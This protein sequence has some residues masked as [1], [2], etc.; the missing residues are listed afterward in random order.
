MKKTYKSLLS[1]TD[2]TDVT[3]ACQNNKWVK[4]HK[5]ILSSSSIFFRDLLL[6]NPHQHPLV[7]LKGV[8]IKDLQ[9]ILQFIYLGEAKVAKDMVTSFIETAKELQVEGLTKEKD[10]PIDNN[11]ADIS[12]EDHMFSLEKEVEETVD[13]QNT[14]D[15]Q[16]PVK[17]YCHYCGFI[18]KAQLKNNRDMIMK[19]HL[20][21]V[22]HGEN[23]TKY[24]KIEA[25]ADE[26][27]SNSITNGE[28]E[29]TEYQFSKDQ[30]ISN[31]STSK[32]FIVSEFAESCIDQDVT[33]SSSKQTDFESDSCKFCDFAT[34]A[35]SKSNREVIMKRHIM[36][37]HD[38]VRAYACDF[39][40]KKIAQKYD[41]TK[42]IQ[43]HHTNGPNINV[44]PSI[45]K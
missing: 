6:G 40:D 19:R 11:Q 1:D 7:Y 31:I 8:N 43:R 39:C 15:Q 2:F 18:T 13:A 29:N 16:G 26:D 36:A 20:E 12:T 30:D 17:D 22:H 14:V 41:M 25:S 42:H 9:A 4:A 35:Q 27:T 28:V 5:V 33:Q 34:K 45:N 32:N 3:L 23:T 44:S 38:K 37:V 10:D 24:V 21:K